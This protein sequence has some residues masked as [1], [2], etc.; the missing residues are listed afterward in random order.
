MGDRA[1]LIIQRDETRIY[2][3]THWRGSQLPDLLAT[4]LERGRP[5]WGDPSYLARILFCELLTPNTLREETGFG[6]STQYGDSFED[7]DLIVNMDTKLI[8]YLNKNWSFHEYLKLPKHT[9]EAL[10]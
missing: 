9:W 8:H 6:I 7:T 3:Y 5:R 2:F 4:G 10:R 1:Q